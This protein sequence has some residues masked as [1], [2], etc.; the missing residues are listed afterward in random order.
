[1]D[2]LYYTGEQRLGILKAVGTQINEKYQN[3]VDE[4]LRFNGKAVS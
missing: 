4:N 1:M 2:V 3:F